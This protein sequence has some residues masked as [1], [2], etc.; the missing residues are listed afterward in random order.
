MIVPIFGHG[1]EHERHGKVH[2]GVLRA[3]SVAEPLGSPP[4]LER[5]HKMRF[6]I[7][8]QIPSSR[9]LADIIILRAGNMINTED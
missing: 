7:I 2:F 9:K 4:S 6:S 1:K 5:H 8:L 3:F